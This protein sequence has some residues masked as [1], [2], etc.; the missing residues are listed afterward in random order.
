LLWAIGA[1]A[2]KATRPGPWLKGAGKLLAATAI[3]HDLVLVTRNVADVDGL[4]AQL[5][6]PFAPS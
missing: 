1:S 6:N 5:L 3:A 2:C 4:G